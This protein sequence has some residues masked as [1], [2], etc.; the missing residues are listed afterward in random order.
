MSLALETRFLNDLSTLYLPWFIS[1]NY[2]YLCKFHF[3][4]I[5]RCSLCTY[6]FLRDVFI[7]DNSHIVDKESK[8]LNGKKNPEDNVPPKDSLYPNMLSD[9][10]LLIL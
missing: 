7:E 1:S 3:F 10:C 9:I 5:N 2:Y 8:T 4:W 6:Y